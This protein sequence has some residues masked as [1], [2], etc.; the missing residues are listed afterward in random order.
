MTAQLTT[1][2]YIRKLNVDIAKMQSTLD[3]GK[4]AWPR[5]LEKQIEQYKTIRAKLLAA[6]GMA[7]AF[8]VIKS[9]SCII[10]SWAQDKAEN[11]LDAWQKAGGQ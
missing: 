2:E 10:E 11:V 9:S 7:K 5:Q 6:E 4:A 3:G 8:E 1:I